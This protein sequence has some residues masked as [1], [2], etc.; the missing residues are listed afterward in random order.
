MSVRPSVRVSVMGNYLTKR[1]IAF[2]KYNLWSTISFFDFFLISTYSILMF[3]I[4]HFQF[5]F[6]FSFAHMCT[7]AHGELNFVLIFLIF[8]FLQFSIF[9]GF[10]TTPPPPFWTLFGPLG[11]DI[12]KTFLRDFSCNGLLCLQFCSFGTFSWQTRTHRH[13]H[14]KQ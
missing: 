11:I 8:L 4:F 1:P 6:S 10:L 14:G 2:R 13:T 9:L 5:S 7:L 3:S 12:F